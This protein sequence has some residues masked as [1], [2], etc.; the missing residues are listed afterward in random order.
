MGP[1]RGRGPTAIR[2]LDDRWRPPSCPLSPTLG[3]EGTSRNAWEGF[4]ESRPT[5]WAEGVCRT[6]PVLVWYLRLAL[7]L[8][9]IN[10]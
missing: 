10:S 7:T 6:R 3:E 1:E 4:D 9:K 2:Q 8:Q 5:L